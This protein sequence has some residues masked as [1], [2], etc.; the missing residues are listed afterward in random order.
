MGHFSQAYL[1]VPDWYRHYLKVPFI[2]TFRT[3]CF[4]FFLRI[5]G[6]CVGGIS[7]KQY[8]H[9]LRV[10]NLSS[11][12]KTSIK[13]W[14]ILENSRK[15]RKKK[16]IEYPKKVY[17]FYHFF[18]NFKERFQTGFFKRTFCHHNFQIKKSRS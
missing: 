6:F 2:K 7:N 3:I 10:K 15:I 18:K 13:F 11:D 17:L 16:I 5:T 1:V 8:R 12:I 9:I 14:K 4:C